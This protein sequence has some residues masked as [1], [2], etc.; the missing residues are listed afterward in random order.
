MNKLGLIMVGSSAIISASCSTEAKTENKK[1]NIIFILADDMGIGDLSCYGQTIIKTP[2]ID[3]LAANGKIFTQHY[4]GSTVSA[5]SRSTFITGLHTGHTPIRGNKELTDREGQLPIPTGTYT[6]AKMLKSADYATGCFGK[7]GLGYIGSEGDA[8][9]QGFD[10]FFGYNC[11]RQAHRYYP[12]HLWHNDEKIILEG[13]DNTNKAIYAPD[14]V[15]EKTLDFIAANKDNPFFAYVAIIQPHAELIAPDDE[16]LA[17]YKDKIEDI[18]YV[19]PKKGSEYG[20]EDFDYAQYCSQ[21]HVHATYAAMVTRIDKYVGEIVAQLEKDGNLENTLII[22]SSDNGVHEAGGND[23]DF[24]NSNAGFRGYKRDLSEG[25]IR[26]PMIMNWKGTI[27]P[28][29]TSDMVSA[30][31]DMMPTFAEIAGVTMENKT[32]GISILPE[33]LGKEQKEQHEFLYWE[34]NNRG[35]NQAVRIGNWKA[36]REGLA[37]NPNAPIKLYDLSN[38]KREENNLAEQHPEI[39]KQ[40]LEIMEREHKPNQLFP[41]G[42][43]RKYV[44]F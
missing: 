41:L 39:V 8:I 34:F 3:K 11:Q 38:D 22:F 29:T 13:N 36:M 18:S 32:D 1:P 10:E 7:W 25:G 43:E 40:A 15:Q 21:T 31:W 9:K 24:F 30:F 26:T 14:L 5:P 17:M 16:I 6:I 4:S 37:K 12:T 19:A 42:E 27:E 35:D 2:N 33:I 23:P 44:V 28:N 20:S